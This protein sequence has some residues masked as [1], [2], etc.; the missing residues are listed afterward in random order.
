MSSPTSKGLDE[1]S[2]WHASKGWEMHINFGSKPL[3]KSVHGWMINIAM[4]LWHMYAWNLSVLLSV[5]VWMARLH[6]WPASH[7]GRPLCWTVQVT[8]PTTLQCR[9][10]MAYQVLNQSRTRGTSKNLCC[11]TSSM[12]TVTV[13]HFQG[14]T[15]RLKKKKK[16]VMVNSVM[17][18]SCCMTM[19]VPM[20]PTEF[21]TTWMPSNGKHWHNVHM[22]HTYCHANFMSLDHYTKL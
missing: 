18:S 20:W 5:A 6:I 13:K 16:I 22:V 14:Y 17:A 11:S 21:L 7:T 1:W 2:M 12:Q 19:S 9:I 4:D 10:K 8:V 3:E 15:P